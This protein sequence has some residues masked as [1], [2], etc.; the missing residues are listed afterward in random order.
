MPVLPLIG[1]H[2]DREAFCA[3]FPQV[4]RD[5]NGFVQWVHDTS[6]ARLLLLDTVMHGDEAGPKSGGYF[7]GGRLEWLQ[8]Q[9]DAAGAQPVLLFMHHPPFGVG[10]PAFDTINLQAD[11]ARA[12]AALLRTQRQ[13]RHLFFGHI[14]RTIFGSWHGIPFSTLPATAHQSKLDFLASRDLF[15][16]EAPGY[17]VVLVEPEQVTIHVADFL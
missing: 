8:A 14:H 2:D 5:A 11:D 7:S 16:H 6:D 12:M 10:V 17:G 3:V 9:F 15:T 4:P 13:V 1:N